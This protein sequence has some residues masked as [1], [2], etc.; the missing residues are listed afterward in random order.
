MYLNIF[1]QILDHCNIN[2]PPLLLHGVYAD[3]RRLSW[4]SVQFGHLSVPERKK[5]ESKIVHWLVRFT[6]SRRR[7]SSVRRPHSCDQHETEVR[8]TTEYGTVN[9]SHSGMKTKLQ[10][11]TIKK[12]V[13]H[14]RNNLY[15][16]IITKIL[17]TK[18]KRIQSFD[19]N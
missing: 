13:N 1:T 7:R 12:C 5:N 15:F 18:I 3:I 2:G 8:E 10:K 17:F 19:S 9:R 14:K 6:S 11:K 4:L 16:K